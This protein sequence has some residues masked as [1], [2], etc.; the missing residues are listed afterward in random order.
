MGRDIEIC[1]KK[2]KYILLGYSWFI[3]FCCF[4]LYSK[5]NQLYIYPFFFRFYAP[6]KVKVKVKFAQSCSTLC[7]PMDCI[8]LQPRILK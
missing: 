3:L 6:M 1:K 4:L 8:V 7:D 2:K 5:V